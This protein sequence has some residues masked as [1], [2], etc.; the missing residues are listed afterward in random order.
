MP[1]EEVRGLLLQVVDR[2][3]GLLFDLV[4]LHPAVPQGYHPAP[5]V[6]AVSWCAC[7]R[8]RQMPTEFERVC[9]GQAPATCISQ[10]PVSLKN[11]SLLKAKY[12]EL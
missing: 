2:Q 9:C 6:M 7:G 12:M 3:P 10:L 4:D 5:G 11:K 8:C 1:E